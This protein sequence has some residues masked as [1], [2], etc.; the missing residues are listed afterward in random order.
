MAFSLVPFITGKRL[1]LNS[2]IM[3]Y[4]VYGLKCAMQPQFLP[5]HDIV[6]E[7]EIPIFVFLGFS[8]SV[9]NCSCRERFVFS[10]L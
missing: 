8:A 3:D 7:E 6:Q 9:N 2:Q 4:L 5:A 1:Q 10:A